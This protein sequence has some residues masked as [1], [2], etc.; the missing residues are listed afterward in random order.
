MQTLPRLKA[1]WEK[2][3]SFFLTFVWLVPL[4]VVLDQATKW[5]VQNSLR[6]GEAVPVIENFFYITLVYT[7]GAAGGAG[8]EVPAMRIIYILIS[9]AMSIAFGFAIWHYRKKHDVFLNLIISLCLGGAIGNL[10]DR[11]FYWPETVGFSGVIDFLM[12]YLQG[13]PN[14]PTINWLSPFPV[15]NVADMCLTIG[16]ILFLVYLV[17]GYV[18][19][20]K[21][22]KKEDA[23]P[24]A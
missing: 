10:I 19:E 14:G 8:G 22:G 17:I 16:V 2:I 23:A 13:G 3:R 20:R 12:F 18:K 15:F 21:E 11:T 24:K 1:F 7:T 5:A 9:W 4:L 6:P